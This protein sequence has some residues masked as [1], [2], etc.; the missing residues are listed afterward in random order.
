MARINELK[1]SNIQQIRECFYNRQVWTKNQLAEK[2]GQS[3]A[4]ITN[5]IQDLVC[6]KEIEYIGEAQSTGGRKSK[7]YILNKDYYHIGMIILKRDDTYYHFIGSTVDLMGSVLSEHKIT[8]EIGNL[9]ELN[10]LIAQMIKNDSKMSLLVIS[11]PG[12][13][14]HGKIDICDFKE[15][16]NC[17]LEEVIFKRYKVPSIIENDVNIASIGL[18]MMHPDVSHLAFIYQPE[19]EYVGCGMMIDH[20]LYNG[21]SHFAGELRYLPFYTHA[22][23]KQL[24]KEN[25][26]SLLRK[27]LLTLCCVF[28]PEMIGVCSDV[29]E[30]I[31]EISLD[32]EIPK[33]HYPKIVEIKD[34]NTMIWDGLYS[35]AINKLKER[36]G[37]E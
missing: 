8:S 37:E 16:N 14:R 27:Q 28:N 18:S 2:T 31:E 11:I 25:P 20:K 1:L 30:S 26:Q 22:Q 34:I 24:L 6:H 23:Q 4:G 17:H 33:L 29:I 15:F 10:Q 13:C 19:A 36:Q 7:Q 21:Y 12:V 9:D 35:I 5:I 32:S 3:L